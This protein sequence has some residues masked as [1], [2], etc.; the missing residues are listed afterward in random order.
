M[1]LRPFY[2][3]LF[4]V[5]VLC[6]T[7]SH[8]QTNT[9]GRTVVE[10]YPI[11][12]SNVYK[13]NN[14]PVFTG[15][16]F[17]QLG[18]RVLSIGE[19][20]FTTESASFSLV[21]TLT[22]SIYDTLTVSYQTIHNPLKRSYALRELK[23]YVDPAT[24]DTALVAEKPVAL[25]SDDI[26]GRGITKSGT[27]IRGFT[28]GSNKDL[29]LQ[30]GLRLQLS[31]K[32][33]DDIE[34]VAALTDEN[35]PIQPEGNTERLD[36]LD[37]VFIR[38]K[39]PNA[40]ATF[41]DYDLNVRTGEFGIVNR[42]LQGLTGDANYAG[43]NA[44]V[45]VASSRGSYTSN[46][47]QGLDG[48][49]GPYRLT[50]ANG[51]RDIIVIAGSEKVFIDGI[52]LKRGENNDYTIDYAS[53]YL[54]F[55]VKRLITSNS[56]IRVEF[57]YSDRRYERN[58]LGGGVGLSFWNNGLTL[59]VSYFREGDNKDSPIDITLSDADKQTL[60]KAGDD[61]FAASKSGVSLAEPDSNGVR[62]GAYMAVDTTINGSSM[63]VYRYDPTSFNS[64]YFVSFSSI[65]LAKGDYVRDAIGNFRFVGVGAG[66]YLPI[67]F[68]PLPQEKRMINTLLSA[69][70]SEKTRISFEFAGSSFDR[71][72]FSEL[73]DK[74]NDGF[75]GTFRLDQAS[76]NLNLFG[77]ELGK[78]SFFIKNRI[79]EER[80]SSFD[81]FTTVE[82]DRDYNTG[83]SAS[84][85]RENLFESE[86]EYQPI[87]QIRLNANYGNL[88]RGELKS[89]R[90]NNSVLIAKKD[91]YSLSYRYD[92]VSSKGQTTE[93]T[94]GKHYAQG[95][96]QWGM[97]QPGFDV[98]QET[99]LDRAEGI[100][101]LLITS[102]Q[103]IDITPSLTLKPSESFE[104]RYSYLMR[105]DKTPVGTGFIRDAFSEGHTVDLSARVG[106]SLQTQLRFLLLDKKYSDEKQR[107][108]LFNNQTLLVRNSNQ[109]NLLEGGITGDLFYETST[110]RSAR[111]EKVFVK[112]EK[113][114]GN[115][116]YLGDLN[117]NGVADEDEFK[118]VLFDGEFIVFTVPGDE[119]FPTVELQTGL[120]TKIQPERF[121]VGDSPFL[122]IINILSTE[123]VVRIEEVNTNPTPSNIYLLKFDNFLNAKNTL[124]GSQLIQQDLF[125]W[126]NSNALSFRFR[127]LER[128]TLSQYSGGAE[129]GYN[130]E[131]SARI[132][133]K[134]IKEISIRTEYAKVS[135]NL[136]SPGA[137]TRTRAITRNDLTFDLS[138]RPIPVVEIGFKVQAGEGSDAFPTKPTTFTTNTQAI[139][140]NASFLGTGRIR[141]EIER[142]EFVIPATG[143]TMPFEL[144]GGNSPGKNFLWRLNFDYRL[145]ANLT[146]SAGYEGRKQGESRVIHQMRAEVRAFF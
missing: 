5:F 125:L 67:I 53:S 64:I 78:F 76:T 83:V 18:D 144:T 126:E 41:G 92:Y 22:Y 145:S 137:L 49:Q 15:T 25:S 60:S 26:F 88:S 45:S 77:N 54:T 56:R 51:E 46:T 138:Y 20:N 7:E 70:L 82:F 37:K 27:I 121:F 65:G 10:R 57:E 80:F 98:K 104:V 95:N 43:Q 44:F 17:V 3:L 91:L 118:P 132:T 74:D 61:R 86:V 19:Y 108:G 105:E 12:Y 73:G 13:L 114:K 116:I 115:Y 90:F 47:L 39:H 100:D 31:G 1:K 89:N 111:L 84:V 133:F 143:N 40:S 134:M 36:E 11:T 30:S 8:S 124:R 131:Q 79:V 75:A 106:S 6:G 66:E 120:R 117:N 141:S 140:V 38:I 129:N 99:K 24:G 93:G 103:F 94:W 33:S 110:K 107:V 112:V 52:P 28:F 119:L 87:E 16:V 81:R 109:Y 58:F 32:I 14:L 122:K 69:A 146:S 55:T 127:F 62:R 113:G 63:V 96:L 72:T 136:F 128:K 48:V 139:R 23:R 59:S 142:I 29:T 85:G 42:K 68:I 130:R 9:S 97:F 135:D 4:A 102:L 34:I 35:T 50:G 101:T 2:A 71:N 123:T 21:D